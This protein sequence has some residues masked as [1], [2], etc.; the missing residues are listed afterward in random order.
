MASETA[1]D[2]GF[3]EVQMREA[4]R[5]SSVDA[6]RAVVFCACGVFAFVTFIYIFF[7]SASTHSSC[8]KTRMSA[9]KC[10]PETAQTRALPASSASSSR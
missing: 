6:V 2:D 7:F 8:T 10:A 1:D 5:Q 4:I 3:E 9:S